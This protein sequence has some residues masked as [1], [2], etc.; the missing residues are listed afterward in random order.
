[1]LYGLL[2]P[3]GNDAANELAF[4]AG[5]LLTNS[6]DLRVNQKAF[7]A[8]MNRRARLLGL[9]NSKFAN[10]HGLPNQEARS[11]AA[12]IAKLCCVCMKIQ[13]FKTIVSCKKYKTI[14]KYQTR[15]R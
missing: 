3:S 8:E 15:V 13:L 1:M 11:T 6:N 14:A 2:L 10:S 9:K 7:I 12:D 5:S 4:W